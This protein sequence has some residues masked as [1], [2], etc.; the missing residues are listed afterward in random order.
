MLLVVAI[1]DFILAK[2][3]YKKEKYVMS[4]IFMIFGIQLMIKIIIIGSIM[5]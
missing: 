2:I 5:W 4:I 3:C 1:I